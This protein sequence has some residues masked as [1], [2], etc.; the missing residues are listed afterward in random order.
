MIA[1]ADINRM[2]KE[3]R[4]EALHILQSSLD[5]FAEDEMESPAWH[6]AVLTERLRKLEA[7]ESKRYTLEECRA[8]FA[9]LKAREQSCSH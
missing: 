4:L 5:E 8:M 2:T 9:E 1:E 6:E 3:E 7:G